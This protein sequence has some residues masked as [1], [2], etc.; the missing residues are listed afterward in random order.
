M[1]IHQ[2]LNF[3]L[4]IMA[5]L[6][7]SIPCRAD[8]RS[9]EFS[10]NERPIETKSIYVPFSIDIDPMERLL[11]FNIEKDPDSIYIGFEPQ[12]FDDTVNG[13]GLLVLGWRADGKIDVY[14][15]PGLQLNSEKYDIA[16]KGLAHIVVREME[17]AFFNINEFGAQ[18]DILFND[19][20]NRPVHLI[21]S[22]SH[23]AKRKPFS[24]L[25]PMGMAA[26][27]P[28]AMPL[29]YLH[30]FYFVRK[31]NTD[32]S[33]T[34][35][36]R[37]HKSDK[38]ALPMDRK[39]MYFT[40]Y[41]SDLMIATINPAF[42][43]KLVPLEILAHNV[44][45]SGSNTFELESNST[46]IKSMNVSNKENTLT[47]SFEPPFPNMADVVAERD[48]NGSFTILGNPAAGVVSGTYHLT[49]NENEIQI[50]MTPCG[51][52][53]PVPTKTSLR[54]LYTVVKTFK[55]WPATYQWNAEI[56]INENNDMIMKSQ[57]VRTM[58]NP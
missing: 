19:I 24:L 18:V 37:N 27:N 14:H 35:S 28:S 30:E 29:V 36:G 15:Q 44:A 23:R 40:R 16:G 34:I 50:S 52:W 17:G 1:N 46:S 8:W 54:F 3:W 38:L 42:D 26:E 5:A 4:T 12:V 32:I 51:G 13:R 9:S 2:I 41:G 21:I 22:E 25:A 10:E 53:K 39:R 58:S 48:Y 45:C 31:R 20:H 49:K 7:L 33:L 56:K 57:W 6:I 11:L 47:I 43:G 55:Q